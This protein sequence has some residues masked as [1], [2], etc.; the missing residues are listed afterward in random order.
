[1]DTGSAALIALAGTGA[2]AVNA[3]AGGGSLIT[4]P[5]L[6]AVGYPPV[7]ANVTNTIGSV[8]GYVGGALGYRRELSQ[9]VRRVVIFSAVTAI[10]AVAGSALLLAGSEEAFV[11]VVPWLILLSTLLL[12]VQPLISRMA[13]R[14]RNTDLPTSGRQERLRWAAAGQLGVAAYGGYFNAGLGIM[15]LGVLGITMDTEFQQLNALKSLLSAVA[16]IVSLVFFAIFA[17]VAWPAAL[18]MAGANLAGGWIGAVLGRRIPVNPLRW[19]I[20]AIGLVIFVILW[21]DN[22]Y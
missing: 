17:V 16:G 5:A 7:I 19:S 6:L 13:A 20:V 12:A 21:I 15:I 10:G 11:A 14:R 3:I 8:P 1:M 22:A 2:G 18:V 4:Y 9:Q